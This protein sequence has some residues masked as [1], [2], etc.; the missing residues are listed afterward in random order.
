[1]TYEAAILYAAQRMREI[2]KTPEQYHFEP[3]RVCGTPAEAAGG[4]FEISAYNDIY[5]L[6]NPEKYNGL[7]ILSDNSAFDSDNP[8]Q[9]GVGEFSGI[10]RFIKNGAT[11]N[12][13]RTA[14]GGVIVPPKP[15]E[16]LRV[17][18]Y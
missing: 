14:D 8:H 6:V 10:I 16:F 1:M 3:I 18:I 4:Y 5:I 2:G 15:V 9:S 12:F 13:D 17:V 7:F 11:W